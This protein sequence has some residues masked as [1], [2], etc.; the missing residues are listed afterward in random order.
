LGN[1]RGDYRITQSKPTNCNRLSTDA[2]VCRCSLTNKNFIPCQD[3]CAANIL[4][5]LIDTEYHYFELPS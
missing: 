5:F 3:I 4:R 2:I 1:F